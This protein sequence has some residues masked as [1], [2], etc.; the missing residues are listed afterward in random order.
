MT[1][2]QICDTF[3]CKKACLIF[4]PVVAKYTKKINIRELLAWA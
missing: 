1:M 4:K 3:P 2:T